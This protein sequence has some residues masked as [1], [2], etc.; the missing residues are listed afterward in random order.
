MQKRRWRR[1][2]PDGALIA[3]REREVDDYSP[4]ASVLLVRKCLRGHLL[5]APPHE[6]RL[7]IELL[8]NQP[9]DDQKKLARKN[10]NE[11]KREAERKRY[12]EGGGGRLYPFPVRSEVVD[13]ERRRSQ[14]GV[15]LW[16]RAKRS[17]PFSLVMSLSPSLSLSFS[18]SIS[19]SLASRAALLFSSLAPSRAFLIGLAQRYSSAGLD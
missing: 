1:F 10:K 17:H 2:S 13:P 6:E 18:P 11:R 9:T 15:E 19:R 14:R 7:K 8:S 5:V 3:H 12:G 16:R 4:A